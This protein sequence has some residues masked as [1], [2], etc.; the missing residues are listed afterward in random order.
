MAVRISRMAVSTEP[1]PNAELSTRLVTSPNAMSPFNLNVVQG[2]LKPPKMRQA[3]ADAQTESRSF[4]LPCLS[5]APVPLDGSHF[6]Q[7]MLWDNKHSTPVL[8]PAAPSTP[9]LVSSILRRGAFSPAFATIRPCRLSG[10]S[11]T[12]I[13]PRSSFS[14]LC[15]LLKIGA[16]GDGASEHVVLVQ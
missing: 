7:C 3:V 10:S 12:I 2:P 9:L 13:G 8:S 5:L 4:V 14:F 15:R 6:K 16:R 11:C 1:V